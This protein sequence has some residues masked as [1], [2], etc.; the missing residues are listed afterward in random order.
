MM[1]AE[2]NVDAIICGDLDLE[3]TVVLLFVCD[4]PGQG[5]VMQK[6]AHFGAAWQETCELQG[7]LVQTIR[8]PPGL[9]TK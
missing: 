3:Y 4:I 7:Q 6:L 8:R 1:A 2:V 5:H 9:A